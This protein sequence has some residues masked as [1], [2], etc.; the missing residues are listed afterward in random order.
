MTPMASAVN[1]ESEPRCFQFKSARASLNEL[2]LTTSDTELLKPQLAAHAAKV[3]MLFNNMP[4][5]LNCQQQETAPDVATLKTLISLCRELSLV[6]VGL[7][8]NPDS[9]AELCTA[10]QLADFSHQRR[11]SHSN[12]DE[13]PKQAQAEAPPAVSPPP[14]AKV[15]TTPVRSGQQIYARDTDLIIL[16]P[17]SAGAEIMADGHIHVYAPLRGRAMAGVNGNTDARIF[18]QS[19]EAE[20]ISIAGYFKTSEDLH[21][22]CW[23][24][25]IQALLRG[26]R[27]DTVSL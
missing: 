26:S 8:T 14:A 21:T 11:A 17:V 18:C 3:P 19:M 7:K 6:P 4:V 1:Q 13:T 9:S 25:P 12:D 5:I 2:I 23:Q 27:L 15:V 10:L 16:A 20:L 24:Q 22:E